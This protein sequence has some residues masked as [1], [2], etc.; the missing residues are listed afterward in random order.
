MLDSAAVSLG[1]SARRWRGGWGGRHGGAGE[2]GEAGE[3]RPRPAW[4][5]NWPE[6]TLAWT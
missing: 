1:G 2:A 4:C 3:K 6:V 5:P